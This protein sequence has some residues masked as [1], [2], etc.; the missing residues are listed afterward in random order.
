M[1]G[2]DG[3]VICTDAQDF[4]QNRQTSHVNQPEALIANF[5]AVWNGSEL[6]LCMGSMEI[7]V[8]Y[9]VETHTPALSAAGTTAYLN[10]MWEM[11]YLLLLNSL[12]R[13]HNVS[14]FF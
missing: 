13:V 11:W 7:R 10:L 9:D 12:V 1:D 4:V 14:A 8:A 6:V 3:V 2:F 5:S